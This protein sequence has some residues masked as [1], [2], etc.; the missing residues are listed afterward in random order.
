MTRITTLASL[1]DAR[2]WVAWI[3]ERGPQGLE[4]KVPKSPHTGMNAASDNPA[5]WG[6]R[7]QAEAKAKTLG[8]GLGLV[9]R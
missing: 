7:A 2:R 6:T 1:A 5:D 3:N 4:T 8:G 9:T